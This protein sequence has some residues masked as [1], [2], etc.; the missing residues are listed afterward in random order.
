[1]TFGLANRRVFVAGHRGMVGSALMR[2]LSRENCEIITA[3]RAEL[4]LRDR[5]AVYRVMRDLPDVVFLAAGRVGGIGANATNRAGFLADNAR[6]ALNVID[7][8]HEA[9]VGRLVYFGSSCIYPREAAQPIAED[10]LLT[11]PLEPTNE[12]YALAKILGARLCD[13][14]REQSGA[15]FFSL[16]P[17]NLYGPGDNYD[18]ASSHV[19]AALIRRFHEAKI[20]LQ[21]SV[22]IW[23]TGTPRRE[24]MHVDDLA[25][26][27]VH[28][29]KNWD[30]SGVINVGAGT[31]LTIAEFASMVAVAV[32]F[33][34]H[35]EFDP[36]K[37]DGTPRKLLNTDRM[38]AMGWRPQITLAD[39]LRDA[40]RWFLTKVA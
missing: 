8:A 22:T 12:G 29:L 39:G 40:Y 31:D 26:A 3:P 10:A 25:D 38:T 7:A 16:M 37:P 17:C 14:Y 13:Y 2:R 33:E 20:S 9:G 30:G 36:S 21:P 34:G 35:L 19:P 24:F 1:M 18:P 27:A 15:E 6:I 4:D 11:G 28:A 23:G 5:Q 32:G